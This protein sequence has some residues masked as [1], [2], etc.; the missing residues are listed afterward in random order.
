MRVG[1]MTTDMSGN[2]M[3]MSQTSLDLGI[4]EGDTVILDVNGEKQAFLT[5]K[6]TGCVCVSHCASQLP[7]ILHLTPLAVVSHSY[8]LC[9]SAAKSR[10]ANNYALWHLS[11]VSRMAAST[12]SLLKLLNL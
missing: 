2:D 12:R 5:V 10:L 7:R 1:G 9:V 8:V 4:C 6:S 3:D 11:L